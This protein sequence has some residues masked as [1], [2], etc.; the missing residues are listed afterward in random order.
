VDPAKQAERETVKLWRKRTWTVD[1]LEGHE[2]RILDCDV[3]I[4]QNIL[5]TSSSDTTIKVNIMSFY[6]YL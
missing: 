2:D 4:E 3:N 6:K 5:V 1:E